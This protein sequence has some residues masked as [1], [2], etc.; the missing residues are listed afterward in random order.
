MNTFNKLYDTKK[1]EEEAYMESRKSN[2]LKEIKDGN[3][4]MNE[5]VCQE[6]NCEHESCKTKSTNCHFLEFEKY[7][8]SRQIYSREISAKI[9]NHF[10]RHLSKKVSSKEMK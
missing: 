8:L 7:K 4:L 2:I 5:H 9:E 10:H 3:E 6:T 1:T